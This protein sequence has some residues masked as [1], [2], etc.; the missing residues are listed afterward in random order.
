MIAATA[1]TYG[2]AHKL[3]LQN[4]FQVQCLLQM[5]VR[6]HEHVLNLLEHLD[7]VH[8]SRSVGVIKRLLNAQILPLLRII[9]RAP[10]VT[11]ILNVEP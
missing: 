10:H 8:R 2:E 6:L 4:R 11:T 7:V 5:L 1:M 3:F 9:F